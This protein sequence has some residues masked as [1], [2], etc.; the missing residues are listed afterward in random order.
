MRSLSFLKWARSLQAIRNT[1]VKGYN[2]ERQIF[3]FLEHNM[4][5]VC[6]IPIGKCRASVS[7]YGYN[8][9]FEVSCFIVERNDKKGEF[10]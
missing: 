1:F 4:D 2:F 10:S 8:T 3:R 6:P 9:H 7:V 5:L